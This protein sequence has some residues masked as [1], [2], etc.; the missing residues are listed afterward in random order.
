MAEDG[1]KTRPLR[2]LTV[3]NFSVI[4]DAKLEFGKITVLIGPQASGK[5]LLCRLAYFFGNELIHLA[6]EKGNR[7][8][9]FPGFLDY[10]ESEFEKRFPRDGWGP[11]QFRIH[12]SQ[13]EYEVSAQRFA[14]GAGDEDYVR[15]EFNRKFKELYE[16][17]PR[18]G[19]GHLGE[20]PG[21]AYYESIFS[22]RRLQ[23]HRPLDRTIYIPAGRSYFINSSRGYRVLA[24]EGETDPV[25]KGFAIVFEDARSLARSTPSVER[26]LGGK[27]ARG[28]T[29][30]LFKFEDGRVL[31]LDKL[32][33][34]TQELLPML[35][36]LDQYKVT[37]ASDLRNETIDPNQFPPDI[38][39]YD[40]FFIEEPEVHVFPST[41]YELVCI[42][43]QLSNSD[44]VNPHFTI[45]THSPY[46]L[47]SFNN[48]I[49]AGQA[50]RNNP[51]LRA[52]IAKIV[53]E[54]YWIKKGDFAAYSIEDGKL[55][56]ILNRSGFVEGN[57]LDQV[58]EVIGNEFDKLLGLEYE[59]TKAS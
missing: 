59:R 39:S 49:E 5:S 41:Q 2:T 12:F 19:M 4:K 15:I 29:G 58:S 8:L 44:D 17:H 52:K 11:D 27:I 13:D 53:P 1:N 48:L 57:Y 36:V 46:I 20:G 30:Y 18:S 54:Q 55:K 16:S 21:N 37:R 3:K 43:A 33:S 34:G 24:A 42:F 22:F 14:R 9:D 45:T 35:C 6:A 25:L 31:P 32:A 28:G 10:V 50:A 51:K 38:Q 23:R 26:Y 56:S 40:E 47:S 7:Q